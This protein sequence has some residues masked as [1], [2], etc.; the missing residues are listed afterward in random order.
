M[1]VIICVYKINYI[2]A[3]KL[4]MKFNDIGFV[5]VWTIVYYAVLCNND[6][7]SMNLYTCTCI[8]IFV[9]LYMYYCI[10]CQLLLHYPCLCIIMMGE[11]GGVGM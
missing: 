7:V 9:T 6:I 8:I 3:N 4:E 11:G 1:L 5:S 2:N 10:S